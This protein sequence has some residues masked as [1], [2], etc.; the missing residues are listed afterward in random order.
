MAAVDATGTAD[1]TL[2]IQEKAKL[3]RVLGRFDLVLFTACAIVGLD[4]VAAA[5]EAGAQAITW[6]VISL[7]LFLIPYGMITAELGSAFP[8][9]GGPYEWARMAFGRP[10]GAVTSIL[11]W[12]SN[13]VWIGGTLTATTIATLNSF[14]V[15]KPLGTT[16]EI[17][18][19][20]VF[21]WVT[22]AIAIVAF[23]IG[24]W[25]PNIGTFW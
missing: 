24:K 5:A 6:L 3:R 12:L 22:V 4:S 19:G 13:P 14:V 9:E 16:A 2:V 18:V 23:R 20:L 25:G 1:G 7:V 8:V 10:A 15:S 21:V 11:Y 17:I